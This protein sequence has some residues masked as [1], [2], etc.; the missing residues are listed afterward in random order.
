MPVRPPVPVFRARASR[1]APPAHPLA[2]AAQRRC[3]SRARERRSPPSA[4][5][6][7]RFP[8]RPQPRARRLGSDPTRQPGSRAWPA[9]LRP[10]RATASRRR[11]RGQATKRSPHAPPARPG[12]DSAGTRRAA[13]IAIRDGRPRA[14]ARRH[15]TRGTGSSALSS[16]SAGAADRRSARRMPQPAWVAPR[17]NVRGCALATSRRASGAPGCTPV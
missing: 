2:R 5:S 6:E 4:L 15:T 7:R 9:E 3:R 1:I 10:Q 16:R 13:A 17:S 8:P 12:S 14:R 11:A